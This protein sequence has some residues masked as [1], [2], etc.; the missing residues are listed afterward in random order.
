LTKNNLIEI[1]QCNIDDGRAY[2]E[3]GGTYYQKGD[4]KAA[5]ADAGRAAELGDEEGKKQ[6]ERLKNMVK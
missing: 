4:L 3:R 5:L 6:Y 1:S 2:R